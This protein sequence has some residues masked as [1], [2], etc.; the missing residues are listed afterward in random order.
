[1]GTVE[2][3]MKKSIEEDSQWR[4]TLYILQLTPRTPE[5]MSPARLFFQRQLR[6]PHLPTLP[7]SREEQYE[8]RQMLKKKNKAKQARNE[9]IKKGEA[10]VELKLG[11]RVLLQDMSSKLWDMPGMVTSVREGN[12][13]GHIQLDTGKVYFHNR[14]YM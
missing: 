4:E 2:T 11:L 8:A 7:D 10:P 1:M 3:L 14:R 9:K 13:S 12:R 5:G 6:I